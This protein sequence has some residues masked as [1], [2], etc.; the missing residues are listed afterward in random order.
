MDKNFDG[1]L[2]RDE[3]IEGL[4]KLGSKD[5]EEEADHLFEVA[6]A[7]ESGNITFSEFCAAAMDKATLLHRPR[8]EAA[9]NM[10]DKNKNG[11]I[12]FQELKEMLKGSQGYKDEI[13]VDL[14]K[15]CDIDGDGEINFEEFEKMMMLA[16]QK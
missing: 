11:K 12:S 9:F 15:E 2:T 10:F 4:K 14:I 13:F 3:I 1:M 16:T 6:D 8:L 5:P 7:D